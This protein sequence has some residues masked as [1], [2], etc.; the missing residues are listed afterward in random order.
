MDATLS[1]VRPS[2]KTRTDPQ[3]PGPREEAALLGWA[4]GDKQRSGRPSSDGTG[5]DSGAQVCEPGLLRAE[6][7]E[8]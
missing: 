6:R 8:G 7:G 2:C 5:E 4:L 3:T 1:G